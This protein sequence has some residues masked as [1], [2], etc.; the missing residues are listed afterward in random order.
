[1]TSPAA[2]AGFAGQG[3]SL[4]AQGD[5]HL[6]AAH[7]ASLASGATTSLYTHAGGLQAIAAHGELSLRAHT[8]TLELLADQAVSVTSVNGQIRVQAASRIELVGGSSKLVLDGDSIEFVTPG[9]FKVQASNHAWQGPGGKPAELVALPQGLLTE[10]PRVMELNYHDEDLMPLA[11][12]AYVAVF[13]DGTS[14]QG[15]LDAQGHA[16]LEGVP[17]GTARVY[18]GE[19]PRTP[20]ARVELP[21]N[22]FQGGSTTDEEAI[23]NLERYFEASEAFWAEQASEEQR[24]V[25]AELNGEDEPEGESLWHYLDA[26][27]QAALR[28]AL[29]GDDA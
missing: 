22:T 10:P 11:G 18:Y 19:D 27:Q 1:M 13:Q 8:D 21:A 14:R 12:V 16:R 28:A 25:R 6:A 7:T 2:I 24:R 9:S 23:A 29:A 5:M 3:L 20:E 4:T 17:P 26:D 15:T